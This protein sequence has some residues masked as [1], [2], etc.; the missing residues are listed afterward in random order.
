MMLAPAIAEGSSPPR[1]L[2]AT[3]PSAN[4]VGGY[5]IGADG[6]LTDITGSPFALAGPTSPFGIAIA[7]GERN[8][9]TADDGSAQVTDFNVD[10]VSGAP[11]TPFAQTAGTN[12]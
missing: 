8:L 7:P 1:A 3:G 10:Q 5:R 4:A 6:S 12:P 2:Y 9:F 11:A